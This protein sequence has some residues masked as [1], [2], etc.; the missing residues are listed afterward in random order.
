M[1]HRPGVY[2]VVFQEVGREKVS[3]TSY[4]PDLESETL[5]RCVRENAFLR[6]RELDFVVHDDGSGFITAGL[7]HKVGAFTWRVQGGGT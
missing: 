5:E 4:L 1:K 7:M 6:S 2:R 3:W